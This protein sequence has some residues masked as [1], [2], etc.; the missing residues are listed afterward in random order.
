MKNKSI[1]TVFIVL[2]VGAVSWYV[3]HQPTSSPLNQPSTKLVLGYRPGVAVD[4]ALIDAVSSG[5]FT[6]VGIDVELKPYGRA[7]LIFAAIK[8]GE[9]QGSLGVPLEPLIDQATKSF[10]PVKAF[11]VWYFDTTHAYDGFVTLAEGPK[12]I[13]ELAGK[14]VASHPSK[15]VTYFVTKM[16]SGSTVKPY[17]PV[18]PLTSLDAG[19]VA[20]VYVLEPFLSI[21]R[22]NPRYR[23][24]ESNSISK[25]LFQSKRVPVAASVLSSEWLSTHASAGEQ[26]IKVAQAAFAN[27]NN[28]VLARA[29]T[30]LQKPEF[31][32]LAPAVAQSVSE[33]LGSLPAD[34]HKSELADFLASLKSG[35]LI[36]SDFIETDKLFVSSLR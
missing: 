18:A 14:A 25:R 12:T 30:N 22:A 32:S 19:D 5:S 24:M 9:I 10:Y 8:S 3:Y 20:A 7:D 33:P 15:Q 36:Q 28:D 31:G 6:S 34:L 23:V 35:G 16:V 13:E 11:Q 17:N 27:A 2:L 21:A 4:L 26:F 29:R 1:I